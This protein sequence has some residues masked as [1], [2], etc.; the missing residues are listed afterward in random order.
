[1]YKRKIFSDILSELKTREIVLIIGSRQVWKSTIL[2]EIYNNHI[3]KDKSIFI[4]ADFDDSILN[5]VSSKDLLDNLKL[6]WYREDLEGTF[7][8][9]IDEFQKIKN[10]GTIIK[11]LYDKFKNIK[12]FL[13]W[14]S[15]ILINKVFWD[16]MLWRKKT[17]FLDKLNFEEFLE[18]KNNKSL[19]N[20]YKN[21]KGIGSISLYEKDFLLSF[22]EYL[23]FWWYPN[24]ILAD[25]KED[26]IK[27]LEEIYNSYLQKDIK[28]FFTL[29]HYNNI[30]R[31][32][33]YLTSINT[34]YLK[35]N[36]ISNDLW[37]SNYNIWKYLSVIEWT[38]IINSLRPFYTN[39]IKTITKTTEL[40]FWDTGFY[41]YIIKNFSD[42]D[43]RMDKWSL[44]ENIVYLEINKNK[45]LLSELYYFRDTK[46]LEVDLILKK[47]NLTIPVEIK[48]WDFNKK[49]PLNLRNF[50]KNNGL[51]LWI[52]IN[53][54]RFEVIEHN[55]NKFIYLPYFLSWKL[56]NIISNY[57]I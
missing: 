48:S 49:P 50:M 20:I 17:F 2:E 44:I 27:T 15:S 13:S 36:S 14:S 56:E 28:D 35:V 52:I 53:K 41:N 23:K 34:N 39:N 33:I 31:L 42:L 8:V 45:S 55:W 3:N 38:Y 57:N 10:I 1:M 26:K 37:I 47:E 54:S 5:L 40:F 16:S 11:W 21:I 32:F 51:N 29:E 43:L 22:N 25:T 24:V 6:N 4:N 19:L 46:W 7:Y 12:F 30:K 18:F 9:F